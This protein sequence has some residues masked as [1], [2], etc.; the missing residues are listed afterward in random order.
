[1]GQAAYFF[2]KIVL[3]QIFIVLKNP[4]LSAVFEPLNLGSNVKHATIRPPTTTEL[5]HGKASSLV[6]LQLVK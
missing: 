3:L 5:L 1:M 6:V 4:S 2:A